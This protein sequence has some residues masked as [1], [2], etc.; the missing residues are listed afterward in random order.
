MSHI[1][2]SSKLQYPNEHRTCSHFKIDIGTGFHF[3]TFQQGESLSLNLPRFNHL[4]FLRKGSVVLNCN[5][6]TGKT[7]HC[8]EMIFIPGGA[9]FSGKA[10]NDAEWIDFVF[11]QPISACDKMKLQALRHLCDDNAYHFDSLPI[12]EPLGMFL[13]LLTYSI[14]AGVNCMHLHAIKHQELFLYIH[15]FYTK[16]E[17]ATF[18][19]P[20]IGKS[21]SFREIIMNVAT[22]VSTVSELAELTHMSRRTFQRKFLEEFNKPAKKWIQERMCARI[23]ECLTIPEKTLKDIM[24]ECGFSSPSSFNQYCKKNLGGPPS[25]IRKNI[26]RTMHSV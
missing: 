6:Y 13:D 15:G 18:F 10:L 2:I 8:D 7:F 26:V 25:E 5:M 9:S 4:L 24:Y 20:I 22:E 14:R 16:Q 23:M 3:S 17:I 1:M 19:Y 11:T 21:M 12:R